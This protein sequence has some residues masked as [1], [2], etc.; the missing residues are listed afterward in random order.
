MAYTAYLPILTDR[1]GAMV[2]HL[3]IVG[4]DL[5][6]KD[7]RAQVRWSGDTPGLALVDLLTVANGNAEGLR[8]VEVI[9]DENGVPTSHVEIV[10]NETTMEGLPYQ[11]EIGDAT[12]LAWDMQVTLA[13]RKK[14]IAK[15]EFEITGDGVTGA[16]VAPPKRVQGYG[17]PRQP[18]S[19]PWKAARL[20]F[21]EEQVT[22]QI[23]DAEL[24][25]PL[26][27]S[28][29]DDA[30]RSQSNRAA[31]ELAA[32]TALASGRYFVSRAAGE[33]GSADDQLFS[34]DDGAGNLIYY[35]RTSGGSLEIG[36]AVT[37]AALAGNAGFTLIKYK[38]PD[39]GTFARSAAERV[40]AGIGDDGLYVN[41]FVDPAYDDAIASYNGGLDVDLSAAF[42]A[43]AQIAVLGSSRSR[44]GALKIAPGR[45][46][47]AQ[48]L[49]LGQFQ[50]KVIGVGR[51][52]IQQMA[53]F[54]DPLFGADVDVVR[55][56]V[57]SCDW[58]TSNA[59]L[60]NH[61]L[62]N[63]I[64][65]GNGSNSDAF[66]DRGIAQGERDNLYA[67]NIGGAVLVCL[68][69][70]DSYYTGIQSVVRAEGSVNE[71]S[72]DWGLI[73]GRAKIGDQNLVDWS[74]TTQCSFRVRFEEADVAGV[75]CPYS[76]TNSYSGMVEKVAGAGVV[77]D[78][79][80][81]DDRF[82]HFYCEGNGGYDFD[83][84]S[85][86][87]Y[88]GGKSTSYNNRGTTSIR[89]RSGAQLNVISDIG[90]A[91]TEIVFDAGSKWNILQNVI[92]KKIT[93][94]GTSNKR[95]GYVYDM[96]ESADPKFY[97]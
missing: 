40:L 11:G 21:G 67:R 93:D 84:S 83:V 85:S 94:N 57:I 73:V 5:T 23:V 4:I 38:L 31:S 26:A 81:F 18:I 25:A 22:V 33:A 52:V 78:A 86:R 79:P 97:P 50:L 76:N 74:P 55:P 9:Y 90:N 66:F 91:Q 92:A 14:R 17:R 2:R 77:L 36:R 45:Y 19:S 39:T 87:T 44:K 60:R 29:K 56:R 96:T 42:N 49:E 3:F 27:K 16:E 10:I 13:G 53:S 34:T 72:P 1:Y 64:V 28:A 15:G 8:L 80:C 32:A 46:T 65:R 47:V 59:Y 89:V 6:G 82:E 88:I 30:D 7:M 68:A 71:Q 51:V 70:V 69:G 20:A 37:P 63:I 24:V 61:V 62:Q 54:I 41:E 58:R 75:Y 48:T 12:Q 43:A 35:R 95:V